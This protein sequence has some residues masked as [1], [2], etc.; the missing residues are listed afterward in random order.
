MTV[1]LSS[2]CPSVS[3]ALC[4]CSL[5]LRCAEVWGACGASEEEWPPLCTSILYNVAP[6][7]LAKT[8][9]QRSVEKDLKK[10]GRRGPNVAP[11]S[12]LCLQIFHTQLSTVS[13]FSSHPPPLP[14]TGQN[15]PDSWIIDEVFAHP[16]V[17]CR[18]RL[19]CRV[20]QIAKG[21]DERMDGERVEQSVFLDIRSI[22]MRKLA[23][24]M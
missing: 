22:S 11:L 21:G 18:A 4:Q 12:P 9:R 15:F 14:A 2:L 13:G 8:N 17:Y 23:T 16:D 24:E 6:R 20:V 10:D 5:V 7:L 1:E 19:C 3:L